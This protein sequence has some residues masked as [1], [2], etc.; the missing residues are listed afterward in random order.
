[1]QSEGRIPTKQK[2]NVILSPENM[3]QKKS[4]M[5]LDYV[6][7][8]FNFYVQNYVLVLN[9]LKLIFKNF[10][11]VKIYYTGYPILDPR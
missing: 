7:L 3:A 8:V 5:Q 6:I 10:N 11:E 9:K 4:Q 1:M 2:D